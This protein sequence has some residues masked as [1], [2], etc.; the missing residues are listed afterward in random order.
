MKTKR[1]IA[2]LLAFVLSFSL[3][4]PA[5]AETVDYETTENEQPAAQLTGD[6]T[7]DETA[8][9]PV[10]EEPEPIVTTLEAEPEIAE[11]TVGESEGKG[12]RN[13]SSGNY[14]VGNFSDWQDNLS[15]AR[16]LSRDI[17]D[18]VAWL[19]DTELNKD[20][21]C[22][23]V[24]VN[25][26]GQITDWYAA[27][28]GL[29]SDNEGNFLVPETGHY[30][31]YLNNSYRLWAERLYA[32]TASDAI[33]NGTVTFSTTDTYLMYNDEVVVTPNAENG[34][35]VDKVYYND[36]E[37]QPEAGVYKFNMPAVDVTVSATF[38]E[39]PQ[40]EP[41]VAKIGEDGYP[42]LQ[43]AV[44][45]AQRMAGNERIDV[46][47]ELLTDVSQ[48]V[49]V[50]QQSNLYLT[51]DGK[52][53]TLTGQ[54]LLDGHGFYGDDTL[55]IKN[56]SFA[57]NS[58]YVQ[59]GTDAFVYVLTQSTLGRLNDLHNLTLENCSFDGGQNNPEF[60]AV[61]A[62]SG[63]QSS[64]YI[65]K[66]LT[67]TNLHSLAQL[68]ATTNV[69][70]TGCN[71][72][73]CENG[74]GFN[75]GAGTFEITGNTFNVNGYGVRLKAQ[76]TANMVLKE[77]TIVAE[78]AIVLGKKDAVSSTI[79]VISGSYSGNIVKSTTTPDNARIVI[80]GGLFTVAPLKAYCADG[81][82][83]I[84]N[85]DPETNT[86]YPYTVGTAVAL[87]DELGYATF[88]A[89][90]EAREN[91]DVVITLLENI[92]DPYTLAADETETL[93][94][95]LD[96]HAL[97]V[98]APAGYELVTSE[99][100][101]NGV[102]TYSLK[103]S[104][105]TATVEALG[106]KTTPTQLV[107]IPALTPIGSVAEIETTYRFTADQTAQEAA[108][109]PFANYNCD[110][111]ISFDKPVAAES[112]GLYGAY[113][114]YG[115]LAFLLNRDM[116]AGESMKLLAQLGGTP[117]TYKDIV[118]LV[119]VFTCGAYNLSDANVGTT[120]TVKLLIWN[121]DATYTIKEVSYTF[122]KKTTVTYNLPTATVTEITGDN[123]H[124]DVPI[125]SGDFE[126]LSSLEV[127]GT[128]SEAEVEYLFTPNETEGPVFD[129]Y[130]N[131]NCDFRVTFHENLAANSFGLF[132][133]Y[134]RYN[135][136]GEITDR[137]N[138]AFLYPY[139]VEANDS[140][141]LLNA[142][143]L[144]THLTYKEVVNL[145]RA[146][147]CG[148]F[149]LSE[150]NYDKTITVEL[151]MW[152]PDQEITTAVVVG[153]TSD[154]YEF[155]SRDYT[156][157]HPMDVILK[158]TA[159][160]TVVDP[161]EDAPL[162]GFENNTLNYSEQ[163]G[164]VEEVKDV[165][166][167]E[168]DDVTPATM[169]HYGDWNCDYRIT[170]HD[171]L[172]AGSF[173]LYGA[174]GAFDVAFVS[175]IGVEA[176]QEVNLIATLLQDTLSYRTV[177]NGISPFTCG[178]YNL[179][180]A[181]I[182]K[183]MT[184]EL[185]IWK[186]GEEELVI[187]T[188]DYTFGD[189]TEV[190]YDSVV[191]LTSR[192]M[193]DPTSVV[194]IPAPEGVD[195]GK[196]PYGTQLTVVAPEVDNY[197]FVGWYKL[198]D[199][200][201][202]GETLCENAEY[203]FVVTE[204]IDLVAVYEAVTG[205][206][207]LHVYGDNYVVF[208]GF[209]SI[210]NEDVPVQESGLSDFD[211]AIGTTNAY[212]EYLGEDFLY[213]VNISNNIVSTTAKYTFTMVGDTTLKLIT[214]TD[215]ET[216]PSVYVYIMNAYKQVQGQG[217]AASTSELTALFPKT[218][219]TLMGGTFAGWTAK[220]ANGSW[221]E[222]MEGEMTLAEFAEA[223]MGHA[224]EE[225]VIVKIT[226]NYTFNA[227]DVYTLTVYYQNGEWEPVAIEELSGTYPANATKTIKVSDILKYVEGIDEAGFSYWMFNGVIDS[228]DTKC[229]F[230][231]PA[232]EAVELV[233]VFNVDTE[234][235]ATLSIAKMFAT[236]DGDNHKISTM[237][238]WFVPED[239]TVHKVGFVYTTNS[240]YGTDAYLM[241]DSGI[242]EVKTNNSGLTG[243]S[244]FFTL[245]LNA[246]TDASKVVY[247]R[248]FIQYTDGE[249]NI[250][251]IY[252]PIQSGSYNTLTVEP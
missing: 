163:I 61:K 75:G 204:D 46:T 213:W 32:L 14:L 234:P 164:T 228:Y 27:A 218:N 96:N 206:G 31:I 196:V 212:V 153:D 184:V 248:A 23:V 68:Y 76:S 4:L 138:I 209:N 66:N 29:P 8:G 201:L 12:D 130:Q 108:A 194:T 197:T 94:V 86:A 83:P 239:C 161:V 139:D 149:N 88:A 155:A 30:R 10:D 151:V 187:A 188:Q 179:D 18:N 171:P 13:I 144:D 215:L 104:L 116:E 232:G 160:V 82:Y 141:Y 114:D 44:N 38:T 57:Y 9:E 3:I 237:L 198:V 241:L 183:T 7:A 222:V 225:N 174:Y 92:T 120:M 74:V 117:W 87:I 235:E 231:Y 168:A 111:E 250:Q 136:Q 54:F 71:V 90:A 224:S 176:D 246:K 59:S 69:T 89:A 67:A 181:N 125:L 152:A 143:G 150:D 115:D 102:T 191:T 157:G 220:E 106:E 80:S 186:D 52:E 132:G 65:L 134:D 56:F 162:Y 84:A 131:W 15:L 252:T 107:T 113:G 50:Q 180:E 110:Y 145:V 127:V 63:V 208:D 190:H 158:P 47:I 221:T 77:N 16:P 240:Q 55:T 19:K 121:D 37:I 93:K 64:G 41:V 73:N 81:L 5:L 62:G 236:K 230:K 140:V 105:P 210:S 34:Y 24:W 245:N 199:G 217:R 148:A 242:S 26:S 156:F 193:A 128:L 2:M 167:F 60:I 247:I 170:F 249:G 226:P 243:K 122:T 205:T 233:A 11:S 40:P 173:G 48:I 165:F 244:G 33:A 227:D 169:A 137:Y 101:E 119:R 51:I 159:T 126:D 178:V 223:I 99:P 192:T 70:I 28:D 53:H 147:Y 1:L 216:D 95:K 98:A 219:P 195:L 35:A 49:T 182:G 112:L 123:K 135:N 78:N 202:S 20:D 91:N 177:K 17:E 172:E 97:N 207:K 43:D 129:A 72:T 22:K 6:E 36:T 189:P 142:F 175:P 146:F 25:E 103:F 45:A 154:E 238:R 85:P 166:M 214:T 79:S 185:V 39:I 211:V 42:S 200:E 133:A 124:K 229:S 100:D 118:A 58:E 203:T 21:T 251:T 109:S